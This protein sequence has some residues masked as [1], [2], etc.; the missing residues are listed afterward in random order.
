[1]ENGIAN[2]YAWEYRSNMMQPHE[3]LFQRLQSLAELNGLIGQTENLYLDCK[4]W[5]Q[6]D[7]EAQRV[8]AKALCGFAN[9]DGGVIV[10]GLEARAGGSKYDADVI[11]RAVPVSDAISV[12]SR[13]EGLVGDLVEPRLQGVLV[14]AVSDTPGS[15]TGFVLIAVPPTEGSPCRSRKQRE[16]Y[17]RITSGTYPMEYFQIADM[18]G[19]RHRPQLHLCLKEG[20]WCPAGEI[21]ERE[22]TLGIEN[23]GRAIARFPSVRFQRVPGINLNAYGIDGNMRFGL[24]LQPTE[25]ELVVFGG[26]A[27]HVI[28]PGTVLKIAKLDQRAKASGWVRA[29]DGRQAFYFEEYTLTA[30]LSADEMP[31]TKDSKTIPKMEIPS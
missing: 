29:S 8:L 10:I 4:I 15:T 12:K 31:V 6:K 19:K 14:A 3:E 27:D 16:F 30:E 5:P 28:Y 23:R 11:Q 13:V 9:A 17:Q 26:G 22:L 1:V 2:G 20:R 18:F 24:P 25:P 7:E 21:Y